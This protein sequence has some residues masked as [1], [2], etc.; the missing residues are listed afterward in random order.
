MEAALDAARTRGAQTIWLGVWERNARAV[1][2]YRKSG[3]TR[4]GEHDFLLG[5]DV[6]TDWLFARSVEPVDR[7]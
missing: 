6:Q 7:P 4:I 2:F 1:A 3:F 5:N